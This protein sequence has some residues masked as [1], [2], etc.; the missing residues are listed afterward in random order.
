MTRANTGRCPEEELTLYYYG[1]LEPADRRAIDKHLE[2]CAACRQQL[3]AL[4][5]LLGAL[6]T[7]VIELSTEE[8]QRFSAQV[9]EHLDRRQKRRFLPL[10]GGG[11]ATAAAVLLLLLNTGSPPDLAPPADSNGLVAELE[12][13]PEMELLRNLDI[14]EELEL[15]QELGDVNDHA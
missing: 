10:F 8:K 5:S 15:L 14:L 7:P 3:A 13:L 11:L 12:G 4:E 1:E 6:P 2:G 9:M